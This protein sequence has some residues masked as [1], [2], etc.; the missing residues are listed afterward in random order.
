MQKALLLIGCMASYG[1][2]AFLMKIAGK[3]LSPYTC[4]VFALPGYVLVALLIAS[5]ADYRVTWSHGLLLA[6]GVLYM[7]GNMAFYKLCQTQDVSL[8]APLTNVNV[9][10]P[11]LLGWGL[12]GEEL[13]LHRVLGIALAVAAVLLLNWPARSPVP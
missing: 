7:L 8:L 2:A 3:R 11:I 12:L 4:A 5:R 10:I 6:I 1:L 9:V 13:T